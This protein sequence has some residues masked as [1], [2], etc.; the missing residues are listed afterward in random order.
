MDKD[1]LLQEDIQENIVIIKVNRSYHENMSDLE[2]YDITRGCWRR[3]IDSVQ[4]A[5]Y[6]FCV[7]FGEIKEVYKIH[8]WVSAEHMQRKTLPYNPE[9]DKGRIAFFGEKAN[10]DIR[11]KYVGKYVDKLFKRGEANPIK[12]FMSTKL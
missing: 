2:L 1:E 9:T 10:D 7:V 3:T 8:N 12:V 11:R 4:D 6:A 5:E